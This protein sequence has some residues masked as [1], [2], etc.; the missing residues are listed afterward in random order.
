MTSSPA[1]THTPSKPRKGEGDK[2]PHGLLQGF[3]A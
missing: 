3:L 2:Q 1:S